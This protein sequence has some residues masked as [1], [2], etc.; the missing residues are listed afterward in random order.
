[1]DDHEADRINRK[2]ELRKERA[3]DVRQIAAIA[4]VPACLSLTVSATWGV[5]SDPM[6][7]GLAIASIVISL[8]NL[9]ARAATHPWS[10]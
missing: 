7:V 2:E 5:T 9:V 3:A 4:A 10:S 1:M 8:G 6:H